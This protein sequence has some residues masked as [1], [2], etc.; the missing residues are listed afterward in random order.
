MDAGAYFLAVFDYA[1][2]LNKPELIEGDEFEKCQDCKARQEGIRQLAAAD[3]IDIYER[4]QV[5]PTSATQ[6]AQHENLVDVIVVKDGGRLVGYDR[7]T[8]QV[9]NVVPK[10]VNVQTIV[11]G[12]Y[13]DRGWLPVMLDYSRAAG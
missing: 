1:T 7:K 4:K 6:N 13:Q 12:Y 2:Y 10:A 3:T 5:A 8:E 11:I 9:T